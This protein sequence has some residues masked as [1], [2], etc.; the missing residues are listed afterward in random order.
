MTEHEWFPDIDQKELADIYALGPVLTVV[1]HTLGSDVA[2]EVAQGDP[3]D[4]ADLADW[5]DDPDELAYVAATDVC[6]RWRMTTS[7][8]VEATRQVLDY[9]TWHGYRPVDE[10]DAGD[11]VQRTAP[12]SEPGGERI[13]I[14]RAFTM[15]GTFVRVASVT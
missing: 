15:S 1:L 5:V 13:P 9:F 3:D 6:Y 8:L 14:P 4:V 12:A 10:F 2:L 11:A 7:D